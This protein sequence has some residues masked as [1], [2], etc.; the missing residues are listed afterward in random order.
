MHVGRR[1]SAASRRSHGQPS[2]WR[3]RLDLGVVAALVAEQQPDPRRAPPTARRSSASERLLGPPCRQPRAAA[4]PSHRPAGG[5]RR[6]DRSRTSATGA[7]RT[8]ASS[9]ATCSARE[10]VPIA[11][12]LGAAHLEALRVARVAQRQPALAEEAL[13]L[14]RRADCRRRRTR[15]PPRSPRRR[16]VSPISAVILRQ[17][18]RRLG[19]QVLVA[20]HQ[21][22][23]QMG[24]VALPAR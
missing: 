14:E 6:A 8:S 7:V 1:A 20:D 23:R 17:L 2:A 21:R 18:R 19:A 12:D 13:A 11:A 9:S 5:A 22:A 15:P 4:P 10:V 16:S 3:D 24:D